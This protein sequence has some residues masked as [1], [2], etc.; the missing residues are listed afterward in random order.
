MLLGKLQGYNIATEQYLD[1]QGEVSLLP[2]EAF[3]V[4]ATTLP[5][6]YDDISSN[7]E[8][9]DAFGPALFGEATG[10]KDWMSL[11]SIILP[12]ITAICGADYANWDSLTEPQKA[13]ALE[14]F[15]TK[16]ISAQGFTFFVTKTGGQSNAIAFIDNYLSKSAIAREQRYTAYMN[17]GYQYLGGAQG[18]KA[19]SSLRADF[20]D[21]TYVK[22]GVLYIAEDGI[23]GLGNW[24]ISDNGYSTDGLKA[25]IVSGEFT[26]LYG[27]ATQTFI[28]TLQGILDNGTY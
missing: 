26:L 16:I 27:M 24:T 3:T 5:T 10:F 1:G 11:R 2:K 4:S 9:W 8:Y 14:Y 25:R 21:V 12:L 17:F 23:E 13:T 7:P 28:D 15:P 18:I 6:D 19:E 22:R 20:L